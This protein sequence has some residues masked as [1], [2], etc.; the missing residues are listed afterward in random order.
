M[1]KAGIVAAVVTTLT[2]AGLVLPAQGCK[3]AESKGAS[4]A[5]PTGG[6]AGHKISVPGGGSG[7]APGGGSAAPVDDKND[8]SFNLQVTPPAAGKA[9]ADA[10]AHVVVTPGT[11]YHVNQDFPTKLVITPPDGVTVAKAEQHKEDAA[12][13]NETK[14]QFDVVLTPAKAGTYK[15][16]GSL[17]FAVCTETSC[18]PK[19]REI[20]FDLAAQ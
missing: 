3:S 19:K 7:Q 4:G 9:G 1:R 18:D 8:T 17:K 11:G 13:F 10:T 5:D 12:T 20:A 2:L 16:A 14:L 6:G 15:V